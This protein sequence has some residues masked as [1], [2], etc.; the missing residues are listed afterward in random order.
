MPAT[1][2]ELLSAKLRHSSA[3]DRSNQRHALAGGGRSSV[4]RGLF[5]VPFISVDAVQAVLPNRDW[6]DWCVRRVHNTAARPTAT[7]TVR[8]TERRTG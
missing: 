4:A 8:A 5:P 7:E 2:A 1:S 3:V 6:P